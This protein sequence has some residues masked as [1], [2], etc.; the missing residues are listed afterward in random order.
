MKKKKG[1]AVLI[2][3]FAIAFVLCT[4]F[5]ASGSVLTV[6]A[7]ETEEFEIDEN[8][9]LVKYNG[10][11]A[12]VTVPEGVVKIGAEAFYGNMNIQRV[13]LPDSCTVIGE[14]A[15]SSCMSL[16]SI[17]LNKTVT[18]EH[19]AFMGSALNTLHIPSSVRTIGESA[20]GS[21]FNLS[22]VTMDDGVESL[23]NN[24]FREC[25]SLNEIQLASTVSVLGSYVFSSTGIKSIDLPEGLLEIPN[26]AFESSSLQSVEI[27]S[28]VK[29]I[30]SYAFNSCWSLTG[31]TLN[32]GLE[33]I[34]ENAFSQTMLTSVHLPSTVRDIRDWVEYTD[35]TGSY[36]FNNHCFFNLSG[37]AS[38]TVEEGNEYYDVYN[39]ALYS[40]DHSRLIIYPSMNNA[41]TLT[42]H[43]DTKI[44]MERAIQY[45]FNLTDVVLNDGLTEIAPYAFNYCG[46]VQNI[47]L[48]STLEKIG[49]GAFIGMSKVKEFIVPEGVKVLGTEILYDGVFQDCSGAEVITLPDTLE[50][51]YGAVFKNCSSLKTITIP[52]FLTTLPADFITGCT[53]LEYIYVDP[54]NPTMISDNGVL[55]VDEGKTLMLYPSGLKNYTYTVN[56]GTEVISSSAFYGNNYIC[57]IELPSSVKSL[58]DNVFYNCK[59]LVTVDLYDT[60]I[61]S[62]PTRAF[63]GSGIKFIELP[64]NIVSIGDYAFEDCKNLTQIDLKNVSSLGMWAFSASGLTSLYIPDTV[65][66]IGNGIL[67]MC[68]NLISVRYSAS[69]NT[70]PS[71]SVY[72][73]SS[74][75]EIII[76]EGV[77]NIQGY[78]FSYL[79]ALTEV[80]F[81]KSLKYIDSNAFSSCNNIAIITVDPDNEYYT[82]VDGILYN[83]DVTQM[84]FFP[85]ALEIDTLVL[86]DTVTSLPDSAFEESRIKH[87]EIPSS[88]T[89]LPSS[90]FRNS[91]I[92]SVVLPE[93]ITYLPW[94]CFADCKNLKEVN[95]EY[96][97]GYDMAVFYGCVSLEKIEMN[98]EAN[99]SSF[100]SGFSGCTSLKEFRFNE[101]LFSVP[102]FI[103]EGCVSLEYVYIPDSV[104]K[105]EASAFYGCTSLK[106]LILPENLVTIE[107]SAFSGSG[108]EH[109]VVLS[110]TLP[111]LVTSFWNP[112]VDHFNF[113]SEKAVLYVKDV[114]VF[115]DW[116]QYFDEVKVFS[117]ENLPEIEITLNENEDHNIFVA[118]NDVF[119]ASEYEIY[120]NGVKVD[121]ISGNEYVIEGAEVGK[122]YNV[123]IRAIPAITGYGIEKSSSASITT[124]MTELE[125]LYSEL[126]A[127]NELI[128]SGNIEK[129][130]LKAEIER[131]K[132][133][134]EA[135]KAELESAEKENTDLNAVIAQL[136]STIED[137]QS[138][139]NN[140]STGCFGAVD[141]E[142]TIFAVIFCVILSGACCM[143]ILRKKE[144]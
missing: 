14:Y 86:P 137:L 5:F 94:N 63:F 45:C 89:S 7:D 11:A 57:V 111:T 108:I 105:V 84:V 10:T 21:I 136:Q 127:A 29:T 49:G 66:N 85:K 59:N 43:P 130:E 141:G 96:V 80:H 88:I 114:E 144:N 121:E 46:S 102:Q 16:N 93:S 41:T 125:K 131:I 78:T 17:D 116:A 62:I 55:Y 44:I 140:Q 87:V 61:I 2:V 103:F 139:L 4:G 36:I 9:V 47:N 110:E 107:A 15:F 37:L 113:I 97:T 22:K 50:N 119:Y 112:V 92:E 51:I 54:E 101:G 98:P 91:A 129:E 35:E 72:G 134:L 90:C 67:Q 99:L 142:I 135:A 34:G 143:L 70:L 104:T 65:V 120:V 42:T 3:C 138:Q 133:L 115:A 64:D 48:P 31:V 106:Y 28:T 83:K 52:A 39:N 71:A 30:G 58:G 109:L 95:L 126:E 33:V 60:G 6:H 13:K 8:N 81:P 32:E 69:M 100:Y 20:F 23:G 79:T 117:N 123:E 132:G 24:C 53:G 12:D 74:L 73:C 38:I 76:P 25:Y 77:E 56:E 18:I 40:K 1:I 19:G 128:A 124:E 26:N 118:W 122:E 75:I 27:P 82:V 68:E